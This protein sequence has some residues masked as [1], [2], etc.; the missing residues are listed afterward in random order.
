MR[1]ELNEKCDAIWKAME[2]T[3]NKLTL[4]L[5]IEVKDLS[6]LI[7]D[8]KKHLIKGFVDTNKTIDK[9][10]TDLQNWTGEQFEKTEIDI[11]SNVR[12]SEKKTKEIMM[13]KIEEVRKIIPKNQFNTTAKYG[14]PLKPMS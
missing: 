3:E 1:G 6:K 2:K 10:I 11:I 7:D 13:T 12:E 5:E 9:K 4:N 14:G 8:N